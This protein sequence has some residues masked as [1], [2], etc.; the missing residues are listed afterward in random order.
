MIYKV[1]VK[2]QQDNT[3]LK[4]FHKTRKV[5]TRQIIIVQ[6]VT[7][8]HHFVHPFPNGHRTL[9]KY[10]TFTVCPLVHTVP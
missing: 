8:L 7:L 6:M 3:L 5:Y 9:I 2:I 1:L 10:V 4:S